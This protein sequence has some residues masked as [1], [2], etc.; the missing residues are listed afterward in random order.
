[1]IQFAMIIMWFAMIIAMV[2]MITSVCHDYGAL[3]APKGSRGEARRKNA[4][5]G[6]NLP[7]CALL[8][9]QPSIFNIKG[10]I[11]TFRFWVQLKQQS[12]YTPYPMPYKLP[13]PPDPLF[14]VPITLV[15]KLLD[16]SKWPRFKK[17]LVK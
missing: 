3:R 1:M 14:E 2:A 12:S 6:Q 4:Q 15:L 8:H 9:F 10:D 11:A 13:P 7:F 16:P 17:K 5:V